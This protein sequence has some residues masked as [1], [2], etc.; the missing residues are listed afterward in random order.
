MNGIEL[1][2]DPSYKVENGKEIQMSCLNSN[3]HI[4][5]RCNNLALEIK[6][7]SNY[8][9]IDSTENIC[10]L[11]S[12]ISALRTICFFMILIEAKAN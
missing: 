10:K 9:P 1:N 6:S 4:T 5:L 2:Y 12:A 8:K 3:R 7:G 11:S